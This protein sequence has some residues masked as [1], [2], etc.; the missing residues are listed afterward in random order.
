MSSVWG[1]GQMAWTKMIVVV[2]EGVPV[3]DEAKVLS[4]VFERC[5]FRRDMELVH[6]PLDIL[7]HSAPALGA[8]T[9]MGLDATRKR[10]GEQAFGIPL[11]DPRLPS[12]EEADAALSALD[13]AFAATAMP[14]WG[15]GRCVFVAVEKRAAGDGPRA[16]E[17]AWSLLPAQPGAG[18]LMVV[19]D[20]GTDLRDWERVLFLMASNADLARDLHRA[21]HRVAIDATVKRDGDQRHGYAV[22][23]YPPLVGFDEATLG[24]ARAV[25]R[26]SGLVVEEPR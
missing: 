17:R 23:R 8:G 20:A 26:A 13:G 5:D 9:K 14:A 24:A 19:V 12:R 10:E 16:I 4:T 22:R 7:D 2:D 25:E 11:G 18:D 3:H 1:A 21:G 6:G 15:H